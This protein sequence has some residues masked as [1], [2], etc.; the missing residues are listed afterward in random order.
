MSHSVSEP[1]TDRRSSRASCMVWLCQLQPSGSSSPG[2]HCLVVTAAGG[3]WKDGLGVP[4]T[5]QNINLKL[6][7]SDS[8]HQTGAAETQDALSSAAPVALTGSS[9]RRT[10]K[11]A[12]GR[13]VFDS[14]SRS[15]TIHT[16]S[17][18]QPLQSGVFQCLER[19]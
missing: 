15:P 9:S 7:P 1:R 8:L 13:N 10:G 2:I 12:G 6:L 16:P 11:S 19:C 18:A 3:R 14:F 17:C 4:L 5:I